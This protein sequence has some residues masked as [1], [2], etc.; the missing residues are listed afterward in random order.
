[1]EGGKRTVRGEVG[2]Y[3]LIIIVR[4]SHFWEYFPARNLGSSRYEKAFISSEYF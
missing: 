3:Y 2:D 1:M 4:T